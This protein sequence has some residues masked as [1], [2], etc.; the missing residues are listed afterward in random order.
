[1]K[2]PP[3]EIGRFDDLAPVIHEEMLLH[4]LGYPDGE[5]PDDRVTSMLDRQREIVPE[6]IRPRGVYGRFAGDVCFDP[7]FPLYKK[8]VYLCVVT[9][10]DRL[11]RRAAEYSAAGDILAA[12]VLDTLGSVYAEGLAEAANR[13]LIS[14]PDDKSLRL[15][16]RISPGYGRWALERQKDIFTLLPTAEIGVSLTPGL[17]MTPRKSVSFAVEI[18]AKPVRVREGD[19]CEYCEMQDC[20]YRRQSIQSVD[21]RERIN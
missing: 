12:F 11:E 9:I 13:R 19:Q 7:G 16:C 6:L 1:M 8:Q 5:L 14:I 18:A 2:P 4:Y 3:S 20:R 15:G 10:G 21:G 17:M